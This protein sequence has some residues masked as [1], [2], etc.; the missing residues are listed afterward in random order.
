VN[1]LQRVVARIRRRSR[2]E[3]RWRAKGRRPTWLVDGPREQVR[4][5][6][7]EGWI[8]PGASVVDLGCGMGN[9]AAWLAER[10]HRVWA[11]D[12][13]SGA[14]RR[15]RARY[16]A[17]PGLRLDRVDVTRPMRVDT[18]YD[19]VLDLGCVHQLPES[20]RPAYAANV[21]RLTRS[22]SRVLVLMRVWGG[23]SARSPADKAAALS[24]HLGTDFE[25]VRAESTQLQG[26]HADKSTPGVELRFVR[27]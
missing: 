13:A 10:G 2:W 24:E 17:V 12:F 6:R 5:A 18:P 16:G 19:V 15:G 22:G 23:E 21:R 26:D 3:R 14:I 1:P 20:A 7:D 25:L 27:H 9:T 4:V 11:V 8:E